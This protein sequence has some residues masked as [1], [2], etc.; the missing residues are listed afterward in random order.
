[1]NLADQMMRQLEERE[2]EMQEVAGRLTQAK[3]EADCLE[4][5]LANLE[6]LVK[7]L[8]NTLK[9]MRRM[10]PTNPAFPKGPL[11]MNGTE[12]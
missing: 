5:Q 7:G 9:H 10:D 3:I 6:G 12:A 1:M 11:M 8:R 4:V 2:R